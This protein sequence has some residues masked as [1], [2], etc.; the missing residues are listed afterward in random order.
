VFRAAASVRSWRPRSRRSRFGIVS[1]VGSWSSCWTSCSAVRSVGTIDASLTRTAATLEPV[2]EE[3]LEQ[4]GS[5]GALNVDET[6]WYLG[7]EPRT[8]WGAFSK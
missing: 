7:G 3:L 8:L 4:T 5:A 2:Y 6:G 1:H